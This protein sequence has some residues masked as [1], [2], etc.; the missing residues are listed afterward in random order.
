VTG[1]RAL[2]GDEGGF[3]R[4]GLG[5][6][7]LPKGSAGTCVWLMVC[8]MSEGGPASRPASHLTLTLGEATSSRFL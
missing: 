2:E 1:E 6:R 7:I 5:R 4:E 8:Y 3:Q